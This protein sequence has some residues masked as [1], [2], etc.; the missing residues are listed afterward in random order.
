MILL[1]EDRVERQKYFMSE[2]NIDLDKYSAVLDNRI[3]SK[4]TNFVQEMKKNTFS[5]DKYT[6]II[7][8]KSAFGDDNINI[9]QKLENHCKQH[10]KPLVLFSG[11]IDTNYYENIDFELLELNSKLFYSD[12][13]QLFLDE[14]QEG[15]FNILTLVYGKHWKLNMQLNILEKLNLQICTNMNLDYEEFLL[16]TNMNFLGDIDI[17]LYEPQIESGIITIHEMQKLA[18]ALEEYIRKVVTYE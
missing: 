18:S 16:D 13:L 5:L 1:I 14:M 4:Y 12:N 7:T 6:I 10:N 8:H 11:G 3:K 17:K 2:T 9:L 15:S